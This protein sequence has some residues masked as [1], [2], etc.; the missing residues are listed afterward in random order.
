[1]QMGNEIPI[2]SRVRVAKSVI[3]YHYPG[4]RNQPYDLAGHEGELVEVIQSWHNRPV[5]ANLPY[6]VKFENRFKAHFQ[7]TELEPVP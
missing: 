7:E 3:V 2:G 4:H 1:M 5:S 6:L